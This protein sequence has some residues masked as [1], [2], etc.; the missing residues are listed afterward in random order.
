[1]NIRVIKIIFSPSNH[2]HMKA[3]DMIFIKIMVKDVQRFCN[4][5]NTF[6]C[7]THFNVKYGHLGQF[8]ICICEST[9]M[10]NIVS[11]VYFAAVDVCVCVWAGVCS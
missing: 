11:P 1:M 3:T 9:Y 5:I 7:D 4:D 2:F 10:L 8:L 6:Y